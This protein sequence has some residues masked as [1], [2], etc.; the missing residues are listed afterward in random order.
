LYA[1]WPDLDR[2]FDRVGRYV[3]NVEA[4]LAKQWAAGLLEEGRVLAIK[5]LTQMPEQG[6]IVLRVFAQQLGCYDITDKALGEFIKQ[7][8]R[9][10]RARL[11]LNTH[12]LVAQRDDICIEV[13]KIR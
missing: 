11:R 5:D 10:D 3:K 6:V 9:G 8:E 1:R 4:L 12:D 2:R 7:C 13:V